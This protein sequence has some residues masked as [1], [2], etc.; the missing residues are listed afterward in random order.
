M[1]GQ[2]NSIPRKLSGSE[3][4]RNVER[5]NMVACAT[6]AGS[7]IGVDDCRLKGGSAT[8][9]VTGVGAFVFGD[10]AGFSDIDTEGAKLGE[11]DGKEKGTIFGCIVGDIPA[12]LKDGAER[13]GLPI[14]AQPQKKSE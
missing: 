5:Y 10:K 9:T 2:T 11:R 13:E 7:P 8:E 4:V 14:G 1:P 6:A 3:A 12:G